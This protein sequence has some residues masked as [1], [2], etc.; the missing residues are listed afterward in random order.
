MKRSLITLTAAAVL[1]TAAPAMAETL[2]IPYQ[3]LNLATAKGQA[4]LDGRID[5]AVREFCGMNRTT[6]GTRISSRETRECYAQTSKQ[7]K[8]KFAAVVDEQRLGG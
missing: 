5:A 7:A 6:T 8:E 4:A 3:D 1:G 2:S